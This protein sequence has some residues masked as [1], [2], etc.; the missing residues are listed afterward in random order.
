MGLRRLGW[1]RGQTVPDPDLVFYEVSPYSPAQ[2]DRVIE[3]LLVLA[4]LEVGRPMK[5][6]RVRSG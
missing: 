2:A 3:P 6:W 4:G 5:T 1:L